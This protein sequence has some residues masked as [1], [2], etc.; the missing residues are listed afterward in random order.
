M[1]ISELNRDCSREAKGKV[2]C[3]LLGSG[4]ER[5]ALLRAIDAVQPN[6]LTLAA[7]QDRDGVAIGH[8]HHAAAK[9]GGEGRRGHEM[10]RQRSSRQDTW[11]SRVLPPGGE[12]EVALA[13]IG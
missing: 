1:T 8:A 2:R 5:L 7:V 12:N 9:V 13:Q 10:E 3:E 6:A 4:A 11:Y